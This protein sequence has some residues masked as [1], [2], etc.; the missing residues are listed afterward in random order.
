MCLEYVAAFCTGIISQFD[1]G[2]HLSTTVILVLTIHN[3]AGS[4]QLKGSAN[5]QKG[6]FLRRFAHLLSHPPRLSRR[7]CCRKR[8]GLP[9]VWGESCPLA[10]GGSEPPPSPG[11]LIGPLGTLPAGRA[12]G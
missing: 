5:S 8:A 6:C 11:G 12:G 1:V 2:G 9:R 10:L 7:G 3:M 4:H